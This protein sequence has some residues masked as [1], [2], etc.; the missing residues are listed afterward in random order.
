MEGYI[1]LWEAIYD[2]YALGHRRVWAKFNDAPENGLEN[3]LEGLVE[4]LKSAHITR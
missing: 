1:Y 4:Y 2:N 3:L